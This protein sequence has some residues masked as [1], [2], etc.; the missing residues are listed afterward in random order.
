M[1]WLVQSASGWRED[2][3]MERY[4]NRELTEAEKECI[5]LVSEGL[6]NREIAQRRGCT[7]QVFKNKLRVIFDKT[8][9][10]T[11]LELAIWWLT[12]GRQSMQPIEV[13]AGDGE[14]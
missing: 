4:G 5:S 10:S 13:R 11:R 2:S 6:T 3:W 1:E 14:I 7:H 12:K 8:G 9:M